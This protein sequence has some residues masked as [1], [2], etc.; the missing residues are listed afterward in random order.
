MLKLVDSPFSSNDYA[1]NQLYFPSL[2]KTRSRKVISRS[3]SRPTIK[4]P[5][6]KNQR[7]IHCESKH[8][9]NACVLMDVDVSVIKF[10]EQPCRIDYQTPNGKFIHY[11]DFLVTRESVKE[12]WEVKA[13]IELESE[14][15][16]FRE[17]LLKELMPDMGYEYRLV[18]G[19]AM[20][21]GV[22]LQNARYLVSNGRL[23][24]GIDVF[25]KALQLFSESRVRVWNDFHIFKDTT[26]DRSTLCRLI[27]E[28]FIRFDDSSQISSNTKIWWNSEHK[29]LEV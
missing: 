14:D 29:F 24:L 6:W 21:D 18:C 22:G 15:I 12:F 23:E 11:P 4:Y 8:E 9:L 5:S 13:D 7:M 17:S 25:D 2:K 10:N 20:S 3:N 26:K 27:L 16:I 19:K 28:G 1:I